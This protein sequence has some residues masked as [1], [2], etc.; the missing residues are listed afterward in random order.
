MKEFVRKDLSR[1]WLSIYSP[2]RNAIIPDDNLNVQKLNR[3]NLSEIQLE[4]IEDPPI[5]LFSFE[6]LH[7]LFEKTLKR[8]GIRQVKEALLAR[9]GS[10]VL[11]FLFWYV[12]LDVLSPKHH[13]SDIQKE[14]ESRLG[15]SFAKN[16][17]LPLDGSRLSMSAFFLAE[18]VMIVLQRSFEN[19]DLNFDI[20]FKIYS[21]ALKVLVGIDVAK[22]TVFKFRKESFK[23]SD[24]FNETSAANFRNEHKTDSNNPSLLR[25]SSV[26]PLVE[27]LCGAHDVP[28]SKMRCPWPVTSSVPYRDYRALSS[29]KSVTQTKGEDQTENS[30][31]SQT[32]EKSKTS[33]SDMDVLYRLVEKPALEH[34]RLLSSNPV[35]RLGVIKNT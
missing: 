24:V 5:P 10:E 18:A 33:L 22:A 32:P 27:A 15:K 26:S 29:K 9:D 1:V 21:S 6:A 35:K 2:R 14:C 13:S 11:T 34:A 8:P 28:G 7:S 25:T 16:F 31:T 19:V 20:I 23:K 17:I 30:S 12:F 3:P 4:S